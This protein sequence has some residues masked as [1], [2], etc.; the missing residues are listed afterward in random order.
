MLAG[1]LLVTYITTPLA[2]WLSL[3][4]LLFIHLGTNYLAVRAVSM[5]TINRQRANIVYSQYLDSISPSAPFRIPEAPKPAWG[6]SQSASYGPAI[7]LPDAISRKERIFERDGVLRRYGL[8]IMGHCSV[9]VPLSTILDTLSRPNPVTGSYRYSNSPKAPSLPALLSLYEEESYILHFALHESSSF[10][11]VMAAHFSIGTLS[12]RF[13]IVLKATASTETQL[14]AWFHAFVCA[15]LLDSQSQSGRS[16]GQN[17]L[18]DGI[19]AVA[20]R[21]T[22][23]DVLST[24]RRGLQITNAHW[25]GLRAGLQGASWDMETGALE[26]RSG[27]RVSLGTSPD[28][29]SGGGLAVEPNIPR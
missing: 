22:D 13:F 8:T 5:R 11:S 18:V 16:T 27:I 1:S 29:E 12:P 14:K 7:P 10:A 23:I 25:P 28:C 17:L 6:N 20:R 21:N 9:G 4:I 2:T 26:T 19:S 24:L 3:F 15:W